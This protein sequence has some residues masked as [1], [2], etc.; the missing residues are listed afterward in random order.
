M[1][2]YVLGDLVQLQQVM[3]NL[4]VN[5]LDAMDAA[6][7]KPAT[8]SI[9]ASCCN[10]QRVEVRVQDNGVGIAEEAMS[11]IF[12]AFYTTKDDGMGMGLA[13]CR[14]IIESH[15]G[16]LH[17]SAAPSGGSI[18]SFDLPRVP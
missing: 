7:E 14:S 15:R 6:P 5:A 8:L 3:L 10:E 1:D 16:R 11:R 17:A 12:D 4:V 18:F 2:V 9:S 13:I